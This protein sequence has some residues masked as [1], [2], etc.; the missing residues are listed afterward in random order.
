MIVSYWHIVRKVIFYSF[1]YVTIFT[2]FWCFLIEMIVCCERQKLS[3]G[4]YLRISLDVK[5]WWCVASG[6]SVNKSNTTCY[7]WSFTTRYW[8]LYVHCVYLCFRISS[9]REVRRSRLWQYSQC[10]ATNKLYHWYMGTYTNGMALYD[11]Y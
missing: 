11:V 4:C 3:N 2:I 10:I 7:R 5:K 1:P 9:S 8:M 6:T